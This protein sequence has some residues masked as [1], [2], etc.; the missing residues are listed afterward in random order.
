MESSK[1]KR[2][3]A[4]RVAFLARVEVFKEK[5]SAGH[6]MAAV[7]EDHQKELGISYSQFANYVNRY[8]RNKPANE[9]EGEKPA[10]E[11]IK[12][13]KQQKEKFTFDA[14]A[15]NKRDDLV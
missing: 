2:L 3:G 12:K 9:N 4:G 7:Y 10:V 15:G 13:D 8:I 14:N 6:T 5:I 1:E 11:P